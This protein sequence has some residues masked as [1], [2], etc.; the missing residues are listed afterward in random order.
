[1]ISGF[2]ICAYW[3]FFRQ[4]THH[5]LNRG[6]LL[7][8]MLLS[9]LLP[10]T[11]TFFSYYVPGELVSI[12]LPFVEVG[13][14]SI[15][16]NE[17]Q[18]LSFSTLV[19]LVWGLGSIILLFRTVAGILKIKNLRGQNISIDGHSV[20]FIENI[21]SPFSFFNRIFIAKDHNYNPSELKQVVLHE[22]SHARLGHTFDLILMHVI[23]IVT[24]WN[25][26]NYLYKSFLR[27]SHEYQVDAYVI[28]QEDAQT[29]SRFLVSNAQLQ[30]TFSLAHHLFS[31]PLKQRIIMMQKHLTTRP[32]SMKYLL[33]FPILATAIFFHS[34]KDQV[35]DAADVQVPETYEI[36]SK[37]TIFTFD[38]ETKSETMKI[39]DANKTVY[40]VVDE[41]PRFPG[42]ESL[43]GEE[44]SKCS[45]KNLLNYIYTS[46]KYPE[47]AKAEGVE[48]TVICK[49]V[50]SKSGHVENIELA[51]DPGAGMGDEVLR[52]VRKMAD[53]KEW[54][55]GQHNGQEVN[56]A[57]TL[58]V[59]FKLE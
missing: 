24:W 15:H 4:E 51:K 38:P 45:S 3:L 50:V 8:T 49:F 14:S 40:K 46:V 16:P 21:K 10:L 56:V 9:L 28:S 48:G 33:I 7:S 19:Y 47:A 25:P 54:V 22:S 20:A 17:G 27:E 58:P 37:D 23:Q 34:C 11:P 52:V 55:P 2:F 31:Q 13:Q 44:R 29:Y 1:M 57:F 5:G 53:E 32:N 42:C 35:V 39:V 30:T 6:Y 41:M 18:S 26:F 36:Q 12:V 59:K 43:A